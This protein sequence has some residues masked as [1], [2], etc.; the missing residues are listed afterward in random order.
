MALPALLGTGLKIGG[1]LLAGGDKKKDQ[2]TGQQMA[3]KMLPG[4]GYQKPNYKP[5]QGGSDSGERHLGAMRKFYG[6]N[7]SQT[8]IK[9]LL[10]L[11]IIFK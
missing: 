10:N 8:P 2:P 6:T 1:A 11:W 4:S 3:Q 7:Q 9:E 5:G